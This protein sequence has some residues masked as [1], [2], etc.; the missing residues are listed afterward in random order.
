MM[1][2][3]LL[4]DDEPAALEY[5]TAVIGKKCPEY[6]LIGTACDGKE[7]LEKVVELKP[8]VLIFDIQMPVMDGLELS[9]KIREEGISMVMIVA[10]GYS[11]FEYARAAMKN[12]CMDYLL[13]P[14]VPR[15]VEK[16]FEKVT[17]QLEEQ[18]AQKR[19]RLLSRLCRD[20]KAEEEELMKYFGGR[21]YFMALVRHKGLPARILKGGGREV[22][23][24]PHE[25]II[26]YGRDE[27][28]ALYIFPEEM[29][30]GE[31]F[32]QVTLH[33][34]RKEFGTEGYCT[35]I[36]SREPIVCGKIGETAFRLY[37]CLNR[38][39]IL[40]KTHVV[41]LDMYQEKRTEMESDEQALL[42]DMRYRA[43]KSDALATQQIM[44]KLLSMWI[45]RERPLLWI[46]HQVRDMDFQMRSLQCSFINDMDYAGREYALEELFSDA[47]AE[48]E[49]VAG[50]RE[51]L[52]DT[53]Q[54]E[55]KIAKLDTEEFVEQ[56]E[57]YLQMHLKSACA[58]RDATRK[59]G[60]SYTY[61]GVLF[62]KYKGMSLKNYMIGLRMEKAKKMMAD[63]SSILIRDVAERIGYQD[64]FYFSRVFRSYT[65]I[66]PSD[67]M[68]SLKRKE[69]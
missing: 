49:F 50:V 41:D 22:F 5:L 47:E 14:V 20:E 33:Q 7:A 46:E 39:I 67:Y 40:G 32:E 13:K 63:D 31:D 16:L 30:F 19:C 64:Q 69:E 44:I 57:R 25:M 53:K 28:E 15:D 23:S 58:A 52:F 18:Y 27:M 1:Y 9:A 42:E 29:M 35:V 21:K 38:N 3:I 24:E 6:K 61:L 17:R 51:V 62:Q 48:E 2:T 37:Q 59:F 45:E 60:I 4:A 34:A 66:C 55:K 68:D 10:S 11:E 26:A 56:V 65:G 36:L 54:E 43:E 8:D 12:G